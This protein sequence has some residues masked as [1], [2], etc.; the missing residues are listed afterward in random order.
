M[1]PRLAVLLGVA[2][3]ALAQRLWPALLALAAVTAAAAWAC[4]RRTGSG[5]GETTE[6]VPL[7][8]RNPFS[9]LEAMKFAAL[10]AV[11]L[12]VVKLAGHYAS[13]R[14]LYLVAAL[15]GLPDVD[16]VSLSLAELV[17]AGGAV[18]RAAQAVLVAVM[19]NTILKTA[20]VWVAGS[21]ALR[22]PI[23]LA[24][25]CLCGV[26]VGAWGLL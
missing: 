25:G 12:V 2:S 18:D 23:L 11:V 5:V 17:R 15:A 8:L 22:R 24:A 9:L 14:A 20:L 16:A 3:P 13:T 6:G 21:R 7:A 10:F 19:S 4:Q 26:A 1:L